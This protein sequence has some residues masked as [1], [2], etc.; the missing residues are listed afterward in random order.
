MFTESRRPS[1]AEPAEDN[2]EL[3]SRRRKV[4]GDRADG[5]SRCGESS[6]LSFFLVIQTSVG[7]VLRPI[8]WNLPGLEFLAT[9]VPL[10]RGLGT[11]GVVRPG[12]ADLVLRV[13]GPIGVLNRSGGV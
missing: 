13:A 7:G 2:G 4:P 9:E 1:R 12:P 6:T 3:N 11:G 5:E 8:V 10:H